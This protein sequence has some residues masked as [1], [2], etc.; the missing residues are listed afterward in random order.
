MIHKH[1]ITKIK[2]PPPFPSLTLPIFIFIITLLLL[3]SHPPPLTIPSSP[4]PPPI[5][6]LPFPLLHLPH[7]SQLTQILSNPTFPFIT[8]II[9][10][11]ILHHIRFFHSPPLHIPKPPT[12]N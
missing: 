11:L 10:S 2:P 4:C 5:L 3:I 9:I 6:P 12:P 8:I 1:F 7:L